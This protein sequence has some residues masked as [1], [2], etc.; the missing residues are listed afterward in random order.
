MTKRKT[1]VPDYT[2]GKETKCD[3]CEGKG[4]VKGWPDRMLTTAVMDDVAWARELRWQKTHPA[5]R[6]PCHTCGGTGIMP[7]Y[8]K[9]AFGEARVA[10][11]KESAKPIVFW[12]RNLK[13]LSRW[14][15]SP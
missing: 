3:T 4:Y 12:G 1:F 7:E 15:Q 6:M 11:A 13:R 5:V 2:P 10:Q 9:P 8:A 14:L